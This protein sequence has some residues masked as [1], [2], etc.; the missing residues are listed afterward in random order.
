MSRKFEA[1]CAMAAS[2]YSLLT[3]DSTWP[4]IGRETY[5]M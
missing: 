4:R 3:T 2:M 1:P 5:G